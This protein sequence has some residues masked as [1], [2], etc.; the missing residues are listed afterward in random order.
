VSAESVCLGAIDV[1]GTPPLWGVFEAS[2]SV[3]EYGTA[4]AHRG[5]GGA[6]M[7]EFLA[8]LAKSVADRCQERGRRLSALG[9]AAPGRVD[10]AAGAV[11]FTA[12]HQVGWLTTPVRETLIEAAGVPASVVSE[13]HA[14]VLAEQDYGQARGCSDFVLVWLGSVVGGGVVSGGKALLGAHAVSGALG[15]FP[16]YPDGNRCSCGRL[17]CLEAYANAKALVG[18]TQGR[19]RT[20]EDVVRGAQAGEHTALS[21][22]KR[23]AG[24]L[25]WAM[26]ALVRVLDPELF[27]LAGPLAERNEVLLREV[28]AE[29]ALRLAPPDAR[30]LRV[31]ASKLGDRA[32]LWG[33]AAAAARLSGKW[34]DAHHRSPG[35]RAR[36]GAASLH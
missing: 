32:A 10:Q 26:A 3:V 7:A 33:A 2:G 31:R 8:A 24:A 11:D 19:Y 27:V 18:F 1:S 15:H 23:Q 14:R 21:A 34:K 28:E 36:S 5:A 20:A 22:V 16:C 30:N 4:P 35:R 29:L 12:A 17:G 13:W 9:V 6:E 25:G